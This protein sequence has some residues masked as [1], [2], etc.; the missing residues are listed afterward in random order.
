[1]NKIITLI[2]LPASGKSTIAKDIS[3][4]ENAIIH[5]SDELRKEL[6]GEEDI[7]DKNDKVFQELH[8]RIKQNL[9][10]G[11]NILYD[12]CNISAKRRKAFLDELK[13]FDCEKI[14]Y[15]IATPYEKCLEQN[16]LRDRQVPEYVIKKMYLNFDVPAYFEG[17]DKIE[18]IYN[19]I[20]EEDYLT[21]FKRLD[22]INQE[23]SH[24][25]WT[26]GIH[27]K[28]CSAH[29]YSIMIRDRLHSDE[30]LIAAALYHDIGKEFTKS[31]K[32]SKGE[33]TEEAHY[34]NHH[35]VSAYNA[36]FYLKDKEYMLD[37]CQLINYH[38]KPFFIDTEKA[39]NK[40]INL[41]GQGFYDRLMLLH[42]AD[43]M[44]QV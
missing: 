1:M 30:S 10:E 4:K 27:C 42:E 6:F 15:V 22:E 41:V 16:K 14:C 36:L 26:I 43:K 8:K 11:K 19:G 17:W 39:R 18:I 23:N 32:N 12:A 44:A 3:I 21:L 13:K 37:T 9:S 25:S 31:F 24:H 20:I 2:G 29:V 28:A 5:A 34:Y 38:M 35:N 40:F 33:I 7:Q